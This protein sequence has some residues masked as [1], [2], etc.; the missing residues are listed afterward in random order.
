[1]RERES[2]SVSVYV[3]KRKTDR[4]REDWNEFS[5]VGSLLYYISLGDR[6]EAIH[7]CTHSHVTAVAPYIF[8]KAI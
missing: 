2:V 6:T 3:C 7:T 4:D 1:M 5:G 8:C